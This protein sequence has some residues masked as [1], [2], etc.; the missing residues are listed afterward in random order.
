MGSTADRTTPSPTVPSARV[1]HRSVEVEGLEI[2]YREAGP[3]DAPT[4]L[5]LHGFPSSSHMFRHLIPALADRFHLVAPDLPGFGYS[6]FPDPGE[7]DYSFESYGRVMDGFVR[8]LGLDRF[9]IYLHDYGCPTGLRLALRGPERVTALIV[10]DGN[11]YEEGLGKEWDDAK[12]YWQ[13]PTEENRRRIP[14]WLDAEGT[15]RQYTAGVPEEQLPLYSP[16][17]WTLDWERM[18]RPGNVEVQF[19]LF[20]DYRTN[21]EMYPRFQEFF[22][23][24]RPPTLVIWGRHDAYFTVA[25]AECYRR[26]LPDA[27]VHVLDAGHKALESHLDE[28]AGLMRGFLERTLR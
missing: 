23:T 7:F 18:R 15:R 22:R 24:R 26:D 3:P 19:A 1:L 20:A 9:A 13:E 8:A 12:A 11:A 10:Q 16:D 4:I 28:I 2:F 21:V 27:E 14:E 6:S 25:E 17:T 5:L